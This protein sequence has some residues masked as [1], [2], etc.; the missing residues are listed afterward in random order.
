MRK[1]VRSTAAPAPVTTSELS[2]SRVAQPTQTQT[3]LATAMAAAAQNQL[4]E[5][6]IDSLSPINTSID[7]TSAIWTMEEDVELWYCVHVSGRNFAEI[8][9]SVLP[10]FCRK[11]VRKRYLILERRHKT[12]LK[13]ETTIE[14]R[15]I[16]KP[17]S[18]TGSA[19]KKET[20][21]SVSSSSS[22]PVPFKV[23]KT[24]MMA[25][26][27]IKET[28]K[29]DSTSRYRH[30]G[31]ASAPL[32]ILPATF[33]N[34]RMAPPPGQMAPPP[35]VQ[36]APSPVQVAPSPIQVAPPPSQEAPQP[37]IQAVSPPSQGNHVSPN[38]FQNLFAQSN[39]GD[40]M[41]GMMMHLMFAQMAQM[42]MNS[43]GSNNSSNNNN[44]N[45]NN[46]MAAMMQMMSQAANNNSSSSSNS[47]PMAAM[48]QMM[49]QAVKSN[50]NNN[51]S[52]NNN[53][54]NNDNDSNGKDNNQGTNQTGAMSP[55]MPDTR[56][57]N[58]QAS[59]FNPMALMMQMMSGNV[60]AN[61]NNNKIN[62]NTNDMN[63]I[64]QG[65]GTPTTGIA[66][67]SAVNSASPAPASAVLDSVVSN[68]NVAP[69][70]PSSGAAI[71]QPQIA[72]NKTTKPQQERAAEE[73]QSVSVHPL[74]SAAAPVCKKS[75][76]KSKVKSK[77]ASAK[78][79]KSKTISSKADKQSCAST[80]G[81]VVDRSTSV[82]KGVSSSAG[83]FRN[84]LSNSNVGASRDSNSGAFNSKKSDAAGV[85]AGGIAG[86]TSSVA[87]EGGS[88]DG[89]SNFDMNS[90]FEFS[91]LEFSDKSRAVFEG[92]NSTATGLLHDGL[93]S[94]GPDAKRRALSDEMA[95]DAVNG[96]QRLSTP[97]KGRDGATLV[98]RGGILP[99]NKRKSL[100]SEVIGGSGEKKKGKSKQN[101]KKR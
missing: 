38:G 54:N 94:P 42:F 23:P 49:S 75:T 3:P 58:I 64:N 78:K 55:M 69:N 92:N 71:P 77:P 17:S 59:S 7:D 19:G 47:N 96:L 45:N 14:A 24:S 80:A 18:A 57:G 31:E 26:K 99:N 46:P 100:F 6:A 37:P 79:N 76:V 90:N 30:A 52:N 98:G 32:P 12:A 13:D 8:S 29:V 22:A 27:G 56:N 40:L 4:S 43:G 67:A 97:Q 82:K 95:L 25:L 9:K 48:M 61:A 101:K 15:N 65:A 83:V 20:P 28:E 72:T 39:G 53:N 10:H 85:A 41:N 73:E 62:I 88:W 91:K 74:Q 5:F 21:K 50:N 60:S 36:V 1:I 16:S 51:S 84:I 89:F 68:N 93:L 87:V 11:E 2:A 86:M 66:T 81:S 33:A 35:P 70:A 63:N 44:A 34:L